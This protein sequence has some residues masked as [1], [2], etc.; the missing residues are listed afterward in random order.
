MPKMLP[1]VLGNLVSKPATRPHPYRRREAFA[2]A[3][4]RIIFDVKQCVFCG[5]CALRCPASAIRVDRNERELVFEP[6][7]CIICGVCV[8]TCRRGCA[9][10]IPHYHSPAYTK[11]EEYY[12]AP[13]EVKEENQL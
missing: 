13:V 7:R 2:R 6:F 9:Q 4:G 8:E 1:T 3:R 5:A 10:M 11:P 12:R